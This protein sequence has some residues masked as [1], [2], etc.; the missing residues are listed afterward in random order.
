MNGFIARGD[1]RTVLFEQYRGKFYRLLHPRPT[2]VLIT[3]CRGRLNAAPFSWNTP[4]SE[5]PPTVAVAVG[6]GS[7]TRECLRTN[8]EATL[9]VIPPEMAD[10]AY[11]LGAAS[12]RDRDKLPELGIELEPSSMVSIPG[13]AGAVAIYEVRIAGS[14]EVGSMDLVLLRVLAVRARAGVADEDGLIL[15]KANV[16]LHGAGNEFFRVDPR[17]LIPSHP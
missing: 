17:P 3:G 10:A 14:V 5:D 15:E 11:A 4:V 8:P 9:N 2:V 1:H 7:F 12:G 13:L 6:R 16:A